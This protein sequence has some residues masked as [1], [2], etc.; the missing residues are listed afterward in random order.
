MIPEKLL[1]IHQELRD[2][3]QELLGLDSKH[4]FKLNRPR[5]VLEFG[6]NTG[7]PCDRAWRIQIEF[8][9]VNWCTGRVR[10]PDGNLLKAPPLGDG[11]IAREFC[12]P[13][14]SVLRTVVETLH[15][16]GGDL[17]GWGLGAQ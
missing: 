6:V 9:D 17:K 15:C 8:V 16:H 3:L 13:L 1:S 2:Q 14:D 4:I 7:N 12:G 5:L 10:D 11:R